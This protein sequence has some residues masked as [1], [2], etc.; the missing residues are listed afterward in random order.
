LRLSAAGARLAAK[1]LFTLS[2]A[3]RADRTQRK[4][5]IMAWQSPISPGISWYEDSVGDRPEYP[6]LDGSVTT[7]VVIIG[8]GFTGLQAAYN[9]ARAGVDVRLIEAHRLGD[10]G[11]GRNGG[12]LGTGQ[13]WWPEEVEEELG[14]ERSR[15]LFKMG[16]AAKAHLFD[17]VA[18]ENIDMD[19]QPGHMIVAHKARMETDFRA[20]AEIA[21]ER[22]D[23]PHLRFMD[24]DETA[25]RVGSHRFHFGVRDAGT[26]HVH[27]MKLLVG[28]GMAAARAGATLHEMTGAS[29][30]R[31]E[32]G[33]VRVETPRGV[34]TADKALIAT[35]S[36]I[37]NLEPITAAHVMP[38][39][40]FIGA[41]PP[42]DDFP[43]VIP[44][45]ESVCDSRFV[46]R[47]FRKSKDNR[48][49]FGGRE[50]YSSEKPDDIT[51]HIR[52]Q[53]TEIYPDLK[54]VKLTHGWGGY[55][56]ITLPRQPFVR[57]VMPHVTSI[58]GYSGHGVML[59]NY[60]GKLYA[61]M[62]SGQ[63]TDLE[64]YRSFN[65]PPFPGG[66][67]F[68]AP[69]LFLALTWFSMLDRL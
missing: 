33:K 15:A 46:V 57:E 40:S 4:R 37:G 65:V 59:S 19:Y 3:V 51:T 60:C 11:S 54:D 41:T 5:F 68:R 32:G 25:R 62:I 17:F 22:Y 69:L 43:D 67:K 13:R 45:G 18:R 44:G 52:R 23:Y 10:G 64:L 9:L 14:L 20:N 47:Y 1:L 36:Y 66:T 24:K 34:I 53:I 28:L 6:P 7:D 31:S 2:N 61:D 42:L 35:N 26:G 27:P 56:G 48:L 49:L 21:A 29:A 58:G 50:I 39:G 30:I 55:V 8:G 16:E 12:Q 38:I 63:A